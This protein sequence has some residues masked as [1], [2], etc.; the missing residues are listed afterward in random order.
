MVKNVVLYSECSGG[1]ALEKIKTR[2]RIIQVAVPMFREKGFDAVTIQDICKAASINKHTFYYHFKAKSELLE[3]YCNFENVISPQMLASIMN[4]ENYVEQ[5]WIVFKRMI[6]FATASGPEIFKRLCMNDMAEKVVVFK[7]DRIKALYSS[8]LPLIQKGKEAGEFLTHID[9]ELLFMLFLQT[10]HGTANW[11]IL[12]KDFD[13]EKMMRI[14]YESLLD[15]APNLRISNNPEYN[16]TWA[17]I[18]G[19]LAPDLPET[20]LISV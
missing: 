11:N 16:E 3:D 7:P 18:K 9:N 12:N 13:F 8:I 1:V 5:I 15:V 17:E 10:F 20:D 2:Q 14:V 19:F 6:E 4:A